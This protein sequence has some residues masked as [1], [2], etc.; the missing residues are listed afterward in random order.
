[1][2]KKIFKLIIC[3]LSLASISLSF[4]SCKKYPDN[5]PIFQPLPKDSTAIARKVLVIV[6]D[7]L[8]SDA[9]KAIAPP[10]YMALI[11]KSKYAWD[12]R[13]DF[14]TTTSASSWKAIL[15]GVGFPT[16]KVADS[17]FV[18][19]SPLN[20]SSDVD[21][22]GSPVNYPSFYYYFL[23]TKYYNINSYIVSSW[24]GLVQNIAN[25]AKY[26]A[27]VNSDKV[28]ADTT[29]SILK[30]GNPDVIVT[31][32]SDP[33]LAVASNAGTTYSASSPKYK[34]A[35]L[36]ADTYIG[37]I[38]AALKARPGY[39]TTENWLVVVTGSHG[40]DGSTFGG[41][42]DQNV[43]VP[44]LY[45][46]ENMKS[47]QFTKQG[48]YYAVT[49]NGNSGNFVSASVAGTEYDFGT[50]SGFTVQFKINSSS[51]STYPVIMSK[52]NNDLNGLGWGVFT[53]GYGSSGD[54]QLILR[55]KKYQTGF[56][57]VFDGQWHTCT[58]A[59]YDSVGSRWVKRFT[60]GKRIPDA[61][62]NI[63]TTLDISAP[64]NPLTLGFANFTSQGN[65]GSIPV[66]FA[67]VTFFNTSLSD[68]EVTNNICLTDIT[69]HPKYANIY[70][71]WPCNDGG[72]SRLVNKI[73]ANKSMVLTGNYS[74]DLQTLYPCSYVP[75]PPGGLTTQ[76]LFNV[77]ISKQ[78]YYWLN[79]TMPVSWAS[80]GSLWLNK[81]E[82][83]F[84]R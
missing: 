83:E 45:Y 56:I 35:I 37:N 14:D 58:F 31:Q 67:D 15:S 65:T 32:L 48:S 43:L 5:P 19:I 34:Q 3:G 17:S 75:S 11:Q 13:C 9:T 33:V 82:S 6:I 55:G 27:I 1:M 51:K 70:A 49:M 7:G 63:G 21:E 54:W 29:I 59:L 8:N 2:T 77:D 25:E 44:T 80:Q 84:Y 60:D 61:N 38:M 69:K 50:K 18:P 81:Y 4:T 23:R 42:S 64:N 52:M 79:I 66:K 20:G 30:N 22:T 40:G 46:N 12:A 72:G 26:K 68:A 53:Y 47:Q 78:I 10:N 41:S 74:W 24:P 73:N 57:D 76:P 39:N 36:Q 28:A 16:H 71:Y 62:T